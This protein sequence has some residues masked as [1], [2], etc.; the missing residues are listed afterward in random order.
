MSSALWF[1]FWSPP[2]PPGASASATAV[3]VVAPPSHGS[4]YWPYRTLDDDYWNLWAARFAPADLA[5]HA[6]FDLQAQLADL[7]KRLQRES[8][9][10][11]AE[12]KLNAEVDDLDAPG[13]F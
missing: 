7:R 4:G 8:A 3:A 12:A 11:A 5:P 10:A 1:F 9:S 13:L 2:W 6:Q